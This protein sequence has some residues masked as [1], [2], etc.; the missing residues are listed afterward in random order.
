MRLTFAA[1]IRTPPELVAVM[2]AAGNSTG[3]R[4]GVY[5]FQMPQRIPAY[6]MAIAAGDIGF[7]PIGPRSGVYAEP[8]VVAS[9]AAEFAD[10]EKMI[11]AAEQRY[12]PYR[13]GRY[14]ILVLPPSF[15]VRR[16]GEPAADVRHADR[17]RRGQDRSSP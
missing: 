8:S 6:L 7:A 4:G 14:D 15:P 2:G 12:G 16:D 1:T 17:A 11:E 9:A 5:R 10:T 13:W 3:S